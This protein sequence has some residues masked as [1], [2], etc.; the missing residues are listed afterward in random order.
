MPTLQLTPQQVI[1]LVE[2]LSAQERES[3]LQLLLTKDWSR[4]VELSPIGKAGA[5]SAAAR[6]RLDWDTMTPLQQEEF[7]DDLAHEDRLA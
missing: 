7:V 3:L 4:W 5:R 1:G 2:Q 6:H